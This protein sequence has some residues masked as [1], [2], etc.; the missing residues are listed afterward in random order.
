[1]DLISSNL[2]LVAIQLRGVVSKL[3]TSQVQEIGLSSVYGESR[4][5]LHLPC[6]DFLDHFSSSSII[7]VA[8]VAF[9][10]SSVSGVDHRSA[11]TITY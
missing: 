10:L 4:T 6:S 7:R 2:N 1:M 3:Q 5:F 9:L 8:D 11:F